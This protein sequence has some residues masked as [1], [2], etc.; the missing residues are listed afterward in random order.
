MPEPGLRPPSIPAS[1]RLVL[2]ISLALTVHTLL[3]AGLP[4]PLRDV[5]ELSHRLV[6]TLQ[7]PASETSTASSPNAAEPQLPRHPDFTVEAPEQITTD[8]AN[9][10]V[11]E[12]V[13]TQTA[14]PSPEPSTRTETSRPRSQQHPASP[15]SMASTPS[16]S[17][18]TDEPEAIQRITL[19]PSEQDP[20]LILLATHL[21]EQLE[22]QRVPAITGLQETLTME[23]ELRLLANG[24]LTRARVVESTGV[25]GI[26][27]AAYRAAL[28]ASPYPEPKGEER[29]RFEVKLVFTPKRR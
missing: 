12:P 24:A 6:F 4:S 18:T 13:S 9:R 20:Y 29:D 3:L 7:S 10:P 25:Q 5:R 8:S 26:D 19:S 1:Y 23:L 15:E 11:A 2:A 28:A 22:R 27:D 14:R 21:A 16:T 17:T